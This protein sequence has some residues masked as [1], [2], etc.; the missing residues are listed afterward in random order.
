VLEVV[1][2]C[3]AVAVEELA[4]ELVMRLVGLAR[5]DVVVEE[6]AVELVIRLAEV[7]E[8]GVGD[9][10]ELPVADEELTEG[11]GVTDD[12]EPTDEPGVDEELVVTVLLDPADANDTE[13]DDDV[14][15]ETDWT[16]VEVLVGGFVDDCVEAVDAV[17]LPVGVELTEPLELG[18]EVIGGPAVDDRT[19]F[20]GPAVGDRAVFGG[21]AV[22]DRAVFGGL[23]VGIRDAIAVAP[24][25]GT[26]A[27]GTL[28]PTPLVT[29]GPGVV[30]PVGAAT[31]RGGA[32][33][34]GCCGQALP[35]S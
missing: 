7:D 32:S 3:S 23:A 20:G 29:T 19:V 26:P 22:G 1:A 25:V 28:T 30:T 16:D 35:L 10:A 2:D 6:L 13:L 21:P 33:A 4:V 34:A 31:V 12:E 17:L 14:T 11:L 15:L 5:A 8:P 9:V 27:V 24:A 18:E